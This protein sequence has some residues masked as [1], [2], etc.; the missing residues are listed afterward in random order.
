M[1]VFQA[2][3]P[4]AMEFPSFSLE[5][6]AEGQQ[7]ETDTQSNARYLTVSS[8]FPAIPEVPTL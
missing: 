3:F 5:Q 4:L 6:K 1:F 2:F 8:R 7:L